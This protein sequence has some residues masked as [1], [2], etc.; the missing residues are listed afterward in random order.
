MVREIP[1]ERRI[2]LSLKSHIFIVLSASTTRGWYMVVS[3]ARCT[4][5][6][7]LILRVKFHT[8]T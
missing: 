3:L 8:L 7:E 5:Q 2:N 4:E 6:Y 1:E